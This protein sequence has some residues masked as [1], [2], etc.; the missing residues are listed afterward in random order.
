[1]K[2]EVITLNEHSF[3]QI[4]ESTTTP[5][6]VDFWAPWCGPCSAIWD[7]PFGPSDITCKPWSKLHVSAG[8]R[9]LPRRDRAQL[10][11]R[12]RTA[13]SRPW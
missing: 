5:L 7:Q 3:E 10:R 12:S 9:M 11:Q 2:T 1:M 4:V 13:V 8:T 6:V